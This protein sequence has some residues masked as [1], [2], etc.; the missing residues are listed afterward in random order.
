MLGVIFRSCKGVLFRSC[1]GVLYR[2]CQG[3]LGRDRFITSN[4][5]GALPPDRFS[6]SSSRKALLLFHLPAWK[7]EA[8]DRSNMA[9]MV[10][11][12]ADVIDALTL[13]VM[14]S[15]YLPF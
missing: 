5:G 3:V 2:S 1:Q 8:V 7:R 11:L 10:H 9:T 12:R 4:S 14:I 15:L 6:T 13:Y